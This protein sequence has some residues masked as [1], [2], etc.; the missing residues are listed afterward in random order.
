[1]TTTWELRNRLRESA[2]KRLA[3]LEAP[4]LDGPDE[5]LDWKAIGA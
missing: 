2:A 4:P 3:I 1:M 5:G